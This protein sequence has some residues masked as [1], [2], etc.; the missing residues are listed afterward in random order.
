MPK[1]DR[2]SFHFNDRCPHKCGFCYMPFDRK[3]AGELDGWLRILDRVAEFEPELVSFAGGDPCVYKDFYE[4]L[5]RMKKRSYVNLISTGYYMKK[6]L[7]TP[8]SHQVD[9]FCIAFDE[10]PNLGPI[11]RYD[12]REFRRFDEI[13]EFVSSQHTNLTINTLVTPNNKDHLAGIADYLLAKGLAHV[14]WN[15]YKFWP[16]E[17]IAEG[18][19]YV[20]TN[21]AFNAAIERLSSVY[22]GRLD[23]RGWHPDER[24]MGY[25]FVTSLG[26]VY[27]VNKDNANQYVFLGSI[28]AEDIFEKWSVHNTPDEVATKYHQI[29]DREITKS[30]LP[31]A[32]GV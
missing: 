29:V 24:K 20:L 6:E 2:I 1:I 13:V 30:V 23:I 4:L 15:L 21:D 14:K 19:K 26:E 12:E 32:I 31:R 17:F 8:V 9:C 3:G 25:F 5:G 22:A 16:F 27:T 18:E 7:Y 28:F 11:Q 10:V